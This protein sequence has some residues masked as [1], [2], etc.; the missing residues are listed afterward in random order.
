MEKYICIHG[1][2]YQP[3]REN[4][5]LEAIEH[6]ESAHPYHDWNRKITEE[7]YE[8]NGRARILDKSGRLARVVNNYSRISFNFGPTLLSWLAAEDPA[9]YGRILEADKESR[10]RFSG[11]GSALAQAYNHPILPLCSH[12]DKITQIQWGIRDFQHRFGR[13]PESLWLPETAVDLETLD[14]MAQAGLKFAVLAPRQ[15][16]RVRKTGERSWRNV[17]AQ[18]LDSTVP[19]EIGLPTGRT[20][21]LFFYNGPISLA[22]G[23]QKLLAD[24]ETFVNRLAGA[25][26]AVR[27]GAQL[28]HIAVDGETF[29]HHHP[30]GDMALAYAL[31]SIDSG[32]LARLTNYGEY[33]EK[34]PPAHRVDIWE[35]TSWSCPHKLGRWKENCGCNTGAH[36]DWHQLWRA[37]LREALDWLRDHLEGPYRDAAAA[38][39]KDPWAARNDYID[40]LLDRSPGSVQ[41]FLARHRTHELTAD[42]QVR[43][44]KLLELQRHALLMYTSC[45]WFFDDISGI[46]TVQILQYAARAIQ[47][48]EALFGED[49]VESSFLDLLQKA[50]SNVAELENGRGVYETFVR[51]AV[52]DARKAAVQFAARS[53]F[54]DLPEQSDLYSYFV[55]RLGCRTESRGEARLAVGRCRIASAITTESS[56]WE[57]G[58]VALDTGELAGGVRENPGGRFEPARFD[59]VVRAFVRGDS[60]E[61]VRSLGA[62]FGPSLFGPESLIPDL[63]RGI[64]EGLLKSASAGLEAVSRRAFDQAAPLARL[65]MRRGMAIPPHFHTIATAALGADLRRVFQDRALSADRAKALMESAAFLQ[66]DLDTEGLERALR[67]TIETLA[68]E[69]HKNP[70]NLPVLRDF[71]RA[72]RLAV[73]LPFKVNFRGTQNRYYQTLVSLYPEFK[74]AAE[75]GD[76]D[77]RTWAEEFKEIGI[78][79]YV[80]VEG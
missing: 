8:P 28:A 12:R 36:P 74:A 76:P 53:L 48:G 18:S 52:M 26:S 1:H 2:F 40:V 11:H 47:L 67:G 70:G 39:L 6:Q 73:T 45:G 71:S 23:F 34:H 3:P 64:L 33:L 65:M 15:A 19:Y 35:N 38:L 72:V 55:T 75:K 58:S 31:H 10:E 30:F 27:E 16:R 62:C 24:G 14:L 56:E 61:V 20:L 68:Q 29:G 41:R 59:D 80:R 32:T 63:Q 13:M 42:E 50:P 43:A 4:P 7:C 69:V 57:Y 77:A 51:P 46:E 37:P 49:A 5:W 60:P 79:L 44:L 22:V 78:L 17:D 21:A 54:E 66:V 9:A 25:F